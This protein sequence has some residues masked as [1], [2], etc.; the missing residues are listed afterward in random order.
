MTL[1]SLPRAVGRQREV[2][3][4]PADGKAVVLGTAGSGKTT[5]AVLRSLYL[6]DKSTDHCGNTLLVTFNR[7]M[8]T[9][10][11]H[12][13]GD[14][15]WPALN[16][17]N[18]HKFARGYL[19]SRG[20]HMENSISSPGQ[21]LRFIKS[22]IRKMLAEGASSSI[23]S[24][25][26]EFFDEE[27]NWIQG[28]GIKDGESYVRAERIGRAGFRIV[29]AE[30]PVVAELYW[31]YYLPQRR[32]GG[33][34]YDWNDMASSVLRE[35]S[36]DEK[37]RRYRHIVIDEGQDFSPEMLRSLSSMVPPGGSLTFF[38]DMAQQIYGRRMSWRDAGL[39]K[40]KIWQFR[41]NYRNTRQI[42]RLALALAGMPHFSDDPDL[43]EPTTPSA[44][45]PLP[46]LKRMSEETKETRFVVAQASKLAQ[47]GT[48]AI[49]CRTKELEG[50]IQE[51]VPARAVKIHS[52]MSQWPVGPR[53]FYGTYHSAK[54]LEFDAVFLPFLS[55]QFWPNPS[56][57]EALG[58]Q[59]ATAKD[60]LLLYV[61]IT[62]AKATLVLTYS[63]KM[64]SLLP[65]NRGL[66]QS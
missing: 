32:S 8:V 54:G 9:H 27:F 42:S 4:L 29:R 13:L 18:Y 10:L 36:S 41:E 51:N 63:G 47:T 45:G 55:E 15:K 16:I 37:E 53:L 49:L 5:L 7:S 1:Q 3:Y 50:L 17:E 33:K 65:R 24:R 2:L 66:Y 28:H 11:K 31:N 20:K 56:D 59:E 58:L 60:S 61:G 30:R 23:L 52:N 26:P 48:V 22:A 38:G 19:S 40:P 35:L 14:V 12:L 34:L 64:T 44:D 46:L 57:I 39:D 25:T 6:S 43:V 62:R 21:R